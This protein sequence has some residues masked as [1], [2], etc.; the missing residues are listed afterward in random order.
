[1]HVLTKHGLFA[2]V[3]MQQLDLCMCLPD[4]ACPAAFAMQQLDLPVC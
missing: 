3:G 1:V 4:D 2:A